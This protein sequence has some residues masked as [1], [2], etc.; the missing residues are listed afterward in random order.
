M[1]ATAVSPEHPLSR[2]ADP[3]LHVSGDPHALW[4]WMREFSPVHRHEAGE[5]PAFWSLT[6]Y[7]DIRSVY[8]DPGGFSSARGVLLRPAR[9]GDDPGGGLT[10]ALSDPPRHKELRSLMADWFS[11][12]AV[13]MLEDSI[14]TA[15]RTAVARALD[16]GG[17]DFV[18]LAGRFSHSVICGII[19]IP[20]RDHEDVYR[21]C[22]EAFSAHT[23]LAAHPQLME[24]FMELLYDR[25]AEPADDLVSALVNGTV[26]GELLSEHEALLNCENI[27]G[28]TENGRLAL[29]GGML[30]FLQHPDQWH[31][32]RRDRAL[33]PDAVEEIVR[34]TSSA[35]HSMRTATR[36]RVIRGERIEAGDRVVLWL[37]SANRD[38]DIFEDPYRFDIARRPNRHIALASGEHFCIGSTL[39]RAEMRALFTALLD[40]TGVIE[41]AGPVTRVRSNAVNGPAALPV[42]LT[43][44]TTPGDGG[45]S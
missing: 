36:P 43:P 34:W 44:R 37:P 29:I 13:R 4:R 32:L 9:L 27:I 11:T 33:L 39:A 8:R 17:C 42:R 20:E 18:H 3:E 40:S 10:L 16:E 6:K 24:Y 23:S 21:W 12:R 38:E 15:A 30:A 2:I 41:Q 35:T 22:E 5:L 19:G 25:M 28:A 26:H 45:F 1:T 7:E 14:R 31:R